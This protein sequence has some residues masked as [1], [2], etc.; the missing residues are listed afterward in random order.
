MN[1]SSTQC[2]AS[3]PAS[4]CRTTTGSATF[5]VPALIPVTSE[6]RVTTDSAR[7]WY[8]TLA[9]ARPPTGI[10]NRRGP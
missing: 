10:V 6:P 7:Q 9:I 3:A 8:G 5:S 2:A 4:K 1:D